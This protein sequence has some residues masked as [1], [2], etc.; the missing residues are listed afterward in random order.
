MM[1]Q[2][3]ELAAKSDGARRLGVRLE[4]EADGA[5]VLTSHATGAATEAAWG[6]DDEEV[7]VRIEANEAARLAFALLVD[8]LRG[9]PDVARLLIDLCQAH[10]VEHA[11]ANW[12]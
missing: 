7:C 9:R 11:V 8:R 3:M 10:D 1:G 12:T 4:L 5:L 2:A 6:A